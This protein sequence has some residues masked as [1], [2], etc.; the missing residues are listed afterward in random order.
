MI[1]SVKVFQICR[2]FRLKLKFFSFN[3]PLQLTDRACLEIRLVSWG[4]LD[5]AISLHSYATVRFVFPSALFLR[6]L[7]TFSHSLYRLSISGV[8]FQRSTR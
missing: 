5:M 2:I 3:N 7:L 1:R 4:N 8:V 6:I